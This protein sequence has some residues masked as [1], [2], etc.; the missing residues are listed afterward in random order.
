MGQWFFAKN[1]AGNGSDSVTAAFSVA[2]SFVTLHVLEYSGLDT[3]SPLD[4]D[5]GTGGS[6]TGGTLTSPAFT[7]SQ[8]SEVVLVGGAATGF[9]TFT[10]G[11]GYTLRT[12]DTGPVAATEDQIFASVQTGITA[13]MTQS[14]SGDWLI[15]V[16]SF[17]ATAGSGGSGRLMLLGVGD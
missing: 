14:G 13:T 1:I 5:T 15:C 4:V 8:A 10:A 16:I 2:E 9:V 17:K 12:Q 3:V 7:T 11:A 6:G